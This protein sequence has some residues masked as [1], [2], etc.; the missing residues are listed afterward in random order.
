MQWLFLFL[1]S[2]TVFMNSS[3]FSF[4]EKNVDTLNVL[5]LIQ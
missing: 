3:L 1:E 4:K 2:R 5:L